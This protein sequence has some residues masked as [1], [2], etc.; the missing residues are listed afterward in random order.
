MRIAI[1]ADQ[2]GSLPAIPPCDLMI[3]SGDL[4]G[5]PAYIDGR[6]RPN[7][8]D[9]YWYDWLC[10]H[11]SW[12]ATAGAPET[13]AIARNHDTC[14]EKFGFPK[15]KNVTYLQDSGCE[16]KGL[17]F[18]G[19]PWIKRWDNLAFNK[20][21]ILLY[22][23]WSSIPL[24]TDVL[25]SHMPPSSNL[26]LDEVD[27]RHVGSYSLHSA[28]ACIEPRLL[29]CGHIHEGR[30]EYQFGKTK[31]VNAACGFIIIDV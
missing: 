22:D 2:H 17:K 7:L 26:R 5:G 27:G 20:D 24:D 4:C 25:V 6:W 10:S 29:T 31:V 21:E 12:W 28:M 16:S 13:I 1:L 18:W 15:M 3:L 23:H 30:G 8:S 9:S 14:I 11:F 19:T